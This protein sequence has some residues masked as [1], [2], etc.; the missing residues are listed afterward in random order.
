MASSCLIWNFSTRLRRWRGDAQQLG[1]LHLVALGFQ[2]RLNDQLALNGRQNFELG[3]VRAHWN[4]VRV[5]PPHCPVVS[6]GAA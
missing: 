2:E 5:K 1:R 3:I 4:R 6:C